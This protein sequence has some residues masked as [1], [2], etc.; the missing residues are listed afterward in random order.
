MK[1][2]AVVAV[3]MFAF[4]ISS[5]GA[6]QLTPLEEDFEEFFDLL[7]RD[8]LPHLQQAATSGQGIGAA[9]I[10]TDKRFF[11]T[12]S[13]GAV[14]SDGISS[15]VEAGD[16]ELLDVSSLIGDQITAAGGFAETAYTEFLPYP[17]VRV[18]AGVRL[19]LNIDIIAMASGIPNGVTQWGLGLAGVEG[20]TLNALNLGLRG[21]MPLVQDQD[22]MPGISLGVGYS[23]S[24]FNIGYDLSAIGEEVDAAGTTLTLV[25][26]FE[27]ADAIHTTGLDFTVSKKLLFFVPY[28]RLSGY[29]QS[30]SFT[31]RVKGFNATGDVDDDGT[32]DIDY[33]EQGGG[34]PEAV[35]YSYDFA[36][37]TAAGFEINL[38]GFG[39][40]A[41]GSYSNA[42]EEFEASVGLR[43]Q[44]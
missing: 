38:G 44:L 13:T 16:F 23:Y 19:P 31:G 8:M 10:P 12:L 36:I 21:R 43:M 41:E 5:V 42:S 14:L 4:A 33:Q 39:L 22:A 2:G 17:M 1:R 24:G 20:A 30:S 11:F 18:S 34:T 9:H 3:A 25:G 6:Q 27:L 29:Y 37:E 35:A 26:D 40:L 7:G 28:V 32:A 15:A